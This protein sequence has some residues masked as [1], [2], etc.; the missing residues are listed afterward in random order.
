MSFFPSKSSSST[1]S[2][3]S[4]LPSPK[5]SSILGT[6]I[7]ESISNLSKSNTYSTW[8]CPLFTCEWSPRTGYIYIGGGGA[9]NGTGVPSGIYITQ[10]YVNVKQKWTKFIYSPLFL[11]GFGIGLF[12]KKKYIWE[13]RQIGFYDCKDRR[14]DNMAYNSKKHELLIGIDGETYKFYESVK[15]PI[16]QLSNFDTDFDAEE[17]QQKFI[18]CSKDFNY[19]VSGGYECVIRIFKDNKYPDLLV[20]LKGEHKEAIKSADFNK[21]NT[22]LASCSNEPYCVIWNIENMNKGDVTVLKK[23]TAEHPYKK[24][25][26]SFRSCFYLGSNLVTIGNIGSRGSSILTIWNENYEITKSVLFLVV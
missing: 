7:P 26:L 16:A 5:L 6:Y 24:K 21:N 25:G 10:I 13:L 11:Y 4:P 19:L 22:R 3:L 18:K 15:K 12:M 23:L 2:F 14:V 1:P 20:E 17:R 9:K 8:G